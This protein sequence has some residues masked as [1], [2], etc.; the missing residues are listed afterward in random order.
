MIHLRW[1]PVAALIGTSLLGAIVSLADPPAG[2]GKQPKRRPRADAAVPGDS[3]HRIAV[4]TA[5]D[6]A[7]QMH[8]LMVTTLHVMHDHYFHGDRARTTIPARALQDVFAEF[9]RESHVDARWI[10][11]NTKAMSIDH[12]PA[13][14]FEKQ[15]AIELASGKESFE[16]IE[17]GSYRRAGA[18][19]LGG[20]CV[21]CHTT[22]FA[23]PTKIPRYAGLVISIPVV[24]Q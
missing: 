17:N 23:P 1:L 2:T 10:S 8:R 11:V 19:L 22:S 16:R 18:I 15:A 24:Q 13:D 20:G 14:D 3:G 5:R 4:D 21:S 9:G 7:A 6:R 12:E